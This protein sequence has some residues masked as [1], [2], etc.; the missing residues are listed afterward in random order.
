MHRQCFLSKTI[1]KKR[2]A[3]NIETHICRP[4][5]WETL[6][7]CSVS[8]I[9]IYAVQKFY[10]NTRLRIKMG[11]YIIEEFPVTKGLRQGCCIL[12]TLFKINICSMRIR[13]MEKESL[14]H[15]C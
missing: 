2:A 7:N 6:E 14:W 12:P 10:K 15:G 11:K 13:R 8:Y 1:I 9:L 3:K 5:K 4:L